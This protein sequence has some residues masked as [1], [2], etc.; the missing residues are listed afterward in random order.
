MSVTTVKVFFYGLFMD[1][2]L[3]A[4]KGIRPSEVSIG[5]I[6]GYALRI[7]QRATLVR[8]PASRAYGVL[9]EIADDEANALYAEESVTDYQPETVTVELMDGTLA[10]A[11][12]YNVYARHFILGQRRFKA[13]ELDLPNVNITLM[14]HGKQVAAAT[15]AAIM[16]NPA[17]SI[18]WL[19]GKLLEHQR[20]FKAGD[21]ALTGAITPPHPI[22]SGDQFEAIYDN[23][24]T[25]SVR[26]S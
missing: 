22:S 8:S 17:R 2:S 24:E 5:Y 18:A 10:E 26:F 9:M 11:I 23:M 12:C 3:L 25:I 7:G 16:G 6:Q 21:I 1:Q 4:A 13:D 15:G 20:H 19:A 14:N